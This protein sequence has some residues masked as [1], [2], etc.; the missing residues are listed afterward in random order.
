MHKPKGQL[1]PIYHS[2][3]PSVGMGQG[4]AK[5]RSLVGPQWATLWCSGVCT[6]PRACP[7]T[8]GLCRGGEHTPS[9]AE[10]VTTSPWGWLVTVPLPRLGRVGLVMVRHSA[11]QMAACSVSNAGGRRA[12]R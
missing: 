5:K 11:S 8:G 4:T 9:D 3:R 1:E 10:A 2:T 7:P 12:S 6:R